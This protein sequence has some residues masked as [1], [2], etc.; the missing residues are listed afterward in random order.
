MP[1]EDVRLS[2][3]DARLIIRTLRH[4]EEHANKT[5]ARMIQNLVDQL[6]SLANRG[7]RILYLSSGEKKDGN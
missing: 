5:E 7:G 1:K 6:D 3:A 4:Y 2:D